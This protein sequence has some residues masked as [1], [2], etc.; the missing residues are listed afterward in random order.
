[1][2][3]FL[4]RSNIPA[5]VAERLKAARERASIAATEQVLAIESGNVLP[6]AME[7]IALARTYGVSVH[8]LMCRQPDACVYCC[9]D[10]YLLAVIKDMEAMDHPAVLE[11][12]DRLLS[13]QMHLR[14]KA[15]QSEHNIDAETVVGSISQR[16][17]E[18]VR[19]GVQTDGD[20]HKQWYLEQIAEALGVTLPDHMPSRVP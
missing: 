6:T 13:L 8:T 9:P 2:S 16:I 14:D 18:L 17:L 11:F 12:A 1:M 15:H 20:R 3:H 4:H 5:Y 19:E 7:L 10:G